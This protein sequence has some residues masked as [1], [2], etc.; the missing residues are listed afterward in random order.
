MKV[1]FCVLVVMALLFTIRNSNLVSTQRIKNTVFWMVW[2]MLIVVTGLRYMVGTDYL[3][4]SHNYKYYLSQDLSLTNQMA[5]GL[6]ARV[7]SWIYDDYATWFFLMS[8]ISFVPIAIVIKREGIA[9]GISTVFFVL[10]G[11]WHGAFNLVKQ[12]AA[13]AF[14]FWGYPYLRDRKFWK[15]C[16]TCCVASLFHM[17][18]IMML[19][20]YFLVGNTISWKRVLVILG[21]GIFVALSYDKLFSVME[22][23]RDSD[24]IS[25]QKYSQHQLNFLRVLVYCAPPLMASFCLKWYDRA[26]KSFCVL[27]NISILNAVLNV[28]TMGS[29]YLHRFVVYT[30]PFS[31]LFIPYLSKPF[32][33]KTRVLFWIAMV[34]LYAV[35]WG[36]DLYKGS[37]TVEFHWI[38]ER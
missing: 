33:Q 8:I 38:F 15:W 30:L 5:L 35:F 29:A 36:Y 10:L 20:V 28:A 37:T 13:V 14:L 4:Y 11:C 3:Q 19:P 16:I 18:A 6:V 26:D 17:T 9:V 21:V 31:A 34:A 25:N 1:Y 27:Y 12:T 23:M 32:K 24:N 2:I 22:W 7:A